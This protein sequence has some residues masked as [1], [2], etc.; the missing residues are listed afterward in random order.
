[1]QRGAS[2]VIAVD[3][4]RGQLHRKLRGD[5]RVTLVEGVNARAL[6]PSDLPGLGKG[7]GIVTIDVS[8]ISLKYILPSV[9]PL[10]CPPADVVALVKP[11]FEAGRADVEPGGLVT[12]PVV[13]ARVLAEVTSLASAIGLTH[14][15]T[16]ES[17]ITG[18]EGNREFFLHLRADGGIDREPRRSGD[19]PTPPA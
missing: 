12:D 9:L 7:A 18:S 2:R 19:S 14:V 10:L 4:G 17:P 11:Q 5:P 8:F 6:E 13:H 15:A 1:L 16:V 3:V